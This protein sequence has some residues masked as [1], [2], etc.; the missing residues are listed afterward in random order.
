MSH[1]RVVIAAAVLTL[2]APAFAQI[3]TPK[4]RQS[5]SPADTYVELFH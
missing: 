2:A 4:V 1:R 5:P 3:A